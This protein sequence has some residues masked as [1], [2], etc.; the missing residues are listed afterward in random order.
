[1]AYIQDTLLPD[2]K[3]LYSDKPHYM[4]FSPVLIWLAFAAWFY[5]TAQGAAFWGPLFLLLGLILFI[6]NAI[7]YYFS[8]YA[9]TNKRVLMK[10]GLLRR[11]SLELFLDRIEGIYVDQSI[12]GRIFG[13]GTVTIGGIGGTKSPF[14][15]IPDPIKF[16]NSVQQQIE[17]KGEP[18]AA[19]PSGN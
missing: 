10:V 13:C 15:Y 9:I 7:I 16:R 4:I 2:E 17:T 18:P 14:H 19:T 12:L 11:R 3:I 8:E 1:M 5:T 6:N